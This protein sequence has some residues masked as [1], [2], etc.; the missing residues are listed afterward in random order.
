[1]VRGREAWYS[2]VWHGMTWVGW[3]GMIWYDVACNQMVV[4]MLVT[5][6]SS[7]TWIVEKV[8]SPLL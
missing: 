1:M 5:C 3:Y 6:S 4:E 7:P 2:T 8:S